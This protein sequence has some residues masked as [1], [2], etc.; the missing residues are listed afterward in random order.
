MRQGELSANTKKTLMS[1]SRPLP[2]NGLLPTELFPIRTQ[3]ERA[4][5]SRM[6]ALGGPMHKFES[7]DSG[8]AP[9][10]K[11]KKLLDSMIAAKTLELKLDAQVMLV[12]NVD[13]GLVNGTVGRVIGFE[14]GKK[15]KDN[16]LLPLVEFRT[17]KGK[18]VLL[19]SREEFRAEDSEGTLLAGRVQVRISPLGPIR[20]LTPL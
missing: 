1:L 16:E 13:G 3:V 11:R 6:A 12:K 5:A 7:R 18:E 8:A 19:V 20:E 10:E 4:N 14:K 17:L 2:F 9:P 15:P